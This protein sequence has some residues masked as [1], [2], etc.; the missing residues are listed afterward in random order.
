[1][2]NTF[3][4]I[5]AL[6][7]ALA[8]SPITALAADADISSA[9]I[10]IATAT[11]KPQ[12]QDE[13][14]SY[15]LGMN[16]GN[17][18]KANNVSLNREFFDAGMRTS[19]NGSEPTMTQQEIEGTMKKFQEEM[20]K[21]QSQAESSSQPGQEDIA[22]KNLQSEKAFLAKNSQRL[23]VTTTASGLQY[24]IIKPGNGRRP[25]ESDVVSV[26]YRGTLLDGTEF[27]S[28]YI[29]N[30]P[31]TFAVNAVIP[32][33]IEALQMMPVGSRW[34]LYIPSELAYGAGGT[35]GTI[36]PNAALIF[37]VDLLSIEQ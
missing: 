28:S 2:K 22:Q 23:G 6:V 20:K 10:S 15:I 35:G 13:K 1:M 12:T 29:R 16:I 36:G 8:I 21:K 9:K 24:E 18:F 33:W 32:G 11:K 17:Q 26:H 3:K 25:K 4:S 30:E 37:E 14:V 5:Q 31:A 27:D 34:K 19:I 7:I